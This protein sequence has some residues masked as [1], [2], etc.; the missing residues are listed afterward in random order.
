MDANAERTRDDARAQRL[1]G[2]LA[3]SL[4]VLTWSGWI[5]LSRQGVGSVLTI[6]D[7]AMLRFGTAALVTAPLWPTYHFSR[8]RWGRALIVA[9][10]CGFP[11][12]L[13]SFAGLR[14]I[15]AASA[16]VIVNGSL[17][18]S[19]ALLAVVFLRRRPRPAVWLTCV[20][21]LAA[22]ALMMGGGLSGTGA[23]TSVRGV[24]CLLLAALVLATYMVAMEAWRFGV[25]DVLVLVPLIN[26]A[27]L[28]PA[29]WL[30]LPSRLSEATLSQIALQSG[31][32]GIVVSVLALFLI[33]EC[34]KRL[35][36]L[37]SS[38]LL[39]WVPACTAAL[40][41]WTLG[42][43]LSGMQQLGIALCS[44]ALV[45]YAASGAARPSAAVDRSRS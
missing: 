35:G 45:Y 33:T 30:L 12:V 36:S 22:D 38:L 37:G 13:L 17:P 32:Q 18:L 5:T 21:V 4:V 34:V 1:W 23:L 20:V 11:Y 8:V 28:L 2:V 24:A 10:G 39:A 19:S 26:A 9:L 14:T 3:G 16:G 41:W 40:A 31:Y 15:G 7:L 27:L 42:E 43:A 25:R 6:Y 44:M 29:W